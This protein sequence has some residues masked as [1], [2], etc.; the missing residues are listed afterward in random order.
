MGSLGDTCMVPTYYASLLPGCHSFATHLY[1]PE[2]QQVLLSSRTFV[3]GYNQDGGYKR[4]SIP[5]YALQ[6]GTKD[7]P[8]KVY[9]S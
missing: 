5:G 4:T 9:P 3:L 2:D 7:K 6:Y 8:L 1:W